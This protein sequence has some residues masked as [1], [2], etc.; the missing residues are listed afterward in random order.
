MRWKFIPNSWKI[1]LKKKKSRGKTTAKAIPPVERVNRLSS[2][3]DDM[4]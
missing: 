1:N 2:R 3:P 4:E